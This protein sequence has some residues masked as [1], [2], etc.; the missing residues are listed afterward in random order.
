MDI[1]NHEAME[2][3]GVSEKYMKWL[4]DYHLLDMWKRGNT[5]RTDYKA[6]QRFLEITRGYD[7][8]GRGD[9]ITFARQHKLI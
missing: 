1:T 8:S 3:L 4:R 5:Y 7:L 2:I 6:I 9:I